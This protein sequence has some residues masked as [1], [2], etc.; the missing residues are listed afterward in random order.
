M[1]LEKLKYEI[2]HSNLSVNQKKDLESFIKSTYSVFDQHSYCSN[3][4]TCNSTKIVKNGLR[5]G[6]QKYICRD[7]KKNFNYR[8]GT[9]LSKVQKLNEWNGFIENFLSLNIT[10]LKE[11]TQKLGLSEQTVFNWRHKLLA[12]LAQQEPTFHDEIIEFDETW[13]RI[14]RKGRQNLGI[15]DKQA[16]K[17]WR[18]TLVGESVYNAKVF[19][20]YGRGNKC[21]DVHLSH[22][23]RTRRQHLGSYFSKHKFKDITVYSDAHRTYKSYFKTVGI[24][25]ETFLGRHHLKFD[26]REVHNQT[27]NAYT[28]GFKDFVNGHLRGVSTKYLEF[29]ARWYQFYHESKRQMNNG[30][31][32][33]FNVD[34]QIC[35]NVVNDVAG[36][37]VFRQ[38]EISFQRFLHNNGRSNYGDCKNHF[39]S[40]KLAA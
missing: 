10:S 18:K 27:V 33:R 17:K 31:L 39:Y 6:I 29:Y 34:A 23:G 22:M 16:Y 11:L 30:E 21:I 37:E 32:L 2:L 3:C 9:I 12:A 8:T 19:F 15:T 25:Q 40:N 36:L 24:D 20:T 38:S 28:R 35:K 26:K 13:F 1:K 4:P 7:C 14:S 5:K